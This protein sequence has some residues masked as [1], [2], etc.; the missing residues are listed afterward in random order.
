MQNQW[1]VIKE[2]FSQNQTAKNNTDFLTTERRVTAVTF[3][4]ESYILCKAYFSEKV[5]F[6]IQI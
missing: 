4:T 3:Q 2:V 1:G 5:S 6:L